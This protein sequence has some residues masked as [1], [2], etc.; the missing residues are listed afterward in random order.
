[1]QELYTP[2][3][4]PS[5]NGSRTMVSWVQLEHRPLFHN[6]LS[7]IAAARVN[8]TEQSIWSPRNSYLKL[9][10]LVPNPNET[11]NREL[12]ETS[13]PSQTHHSHDMSTHLSTVNLADGI[14]V[15]RDTDEQDNEELFYEEI[16]PMD[17]G[18]DA[19]DFIETLRGKMPSPI[20]MRIASTSTSS[21]PF[22][23]SA[24]SYT[25][26]DLSLAT[27]STDLEYHPRPFTSLNI[28]P[29]IMGIGGDDSWTACVHEEY[30]LPPEEYSYGFTFSFHS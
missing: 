24:Q 18:N 21:N 1:M 4:V 9:D 27:H 25:T 26:E 8:Q 14:P 23:F 7:D 17:Q 13:I 10:G 6:S 16:A 29:F 20:I 30:L 19:N 11:P 2:Y 3:I 12:S 22:N 5:E 15:L 28:D